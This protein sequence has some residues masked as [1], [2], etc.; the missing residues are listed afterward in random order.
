MAATGEGTRATA[1]VGVGA[2][3]RVEEV[4]GGLKAFLPCVSGR[5]F[6][7]LSIFVVPAPQATA[8]TRRAASV[9][10]RRSWSR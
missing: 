6:D 8:T 7:A 9:T 3:S 2:S 5:C 1:C 4:G 10:S